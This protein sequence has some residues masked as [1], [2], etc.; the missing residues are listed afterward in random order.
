MHAQ[1]QAERMQNIWSTSFI[2]L[3]LMGLCRNSDGLS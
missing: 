3:F 1:H 2:T